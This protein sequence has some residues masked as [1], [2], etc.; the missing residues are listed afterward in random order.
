MDAYPYD[1]LCRMLDSDDPPPAPLTRRQIRE[2][3]S[4]R[5]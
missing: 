5:Q 1:A 4:I 3:Q 2:V